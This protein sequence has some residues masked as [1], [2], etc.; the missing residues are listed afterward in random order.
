MA[1][2]HFLRREAPHV[3]WMALAKITY[4]NPLLEV[5]QLLNNMHGNEYI[6]NVKVFVLIRFFFVDVKLTCESFIFGF[7]KIR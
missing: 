1:H 7:Q 6:L 4:V 3:S 5:A 2:K